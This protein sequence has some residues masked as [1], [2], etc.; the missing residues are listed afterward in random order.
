M[1]SLGVWF[2]LLISLAASFN[3]ASHGKLFRVSNSYGNREFPK[4]LEAESPVR[5]T[6]RIIRKEYCAGDG[7]E[8]QTLMLYL[9]A[10]LTNTSRKTL[11]LYKGVNVVGELISRNPSD[12]S[13]GRYV[14]SSTLTVYSAGAKD[15]SKAVRPTGDFI[16]LSPMKSFEVKIRVPII[17]KNSNRLSGTAAIDQPDPFGALPL[18]EYVLQTRVS[19]WDN[20]IDEAQTLRNRWKRRGLL[21]FDDVTSQPMKF[22]V[23]KPE[24]VTTCR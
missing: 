20:S 10:H 15:F 21:W 1:T 24:H 4:Q 17:V 11:I 9:R 8:Y 2:C 3:A 13:A 12:A 7:P 16:I 18:G 5:L 19:I 23:E 6:T 14:S 22:R